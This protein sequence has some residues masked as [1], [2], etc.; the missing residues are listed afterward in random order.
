MVTRRTLAHTRSTGVAL[1]VLMATATLIG[2][3][4]VTENPHESKTVEGDEAIALIDS[5]RAK[6]SYEAARQR[7]TD[8]ARTIAQRIVDAVPSQTWQFSTNPDVREVKG[9]GLPCEKLTGSVALKPLADLVE[10]GRLFSGDEFRMAADIV[11]EEAAK[12]GATGESSLFNDDS[13]RDIDIRGAGYE[14]NLRQ[15]KGAILNITGDCFLKQR[16]IDL[17]PASSR[18]HR[19]SCRHNPR[20]PHESACVQD[21]TAAHQPELGMVDKR[22]TALCI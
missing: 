8:T 12:F 22:Q 17:P 20:R 9:D 1:A 5:M 19:P 11:R 10:F 3:C 7:L 14:F 15:S 4:S 18:H 13:R 6:G 16:V 21:T 2:G